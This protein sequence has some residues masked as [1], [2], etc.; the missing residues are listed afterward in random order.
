MG[1][2]DFHKWL[3]NNLTPYIENDAIKGEIDNLYID[4]NFLLHYCSYN[5]PPNKLLDKIAR[6]ITRFI[7]E[8]KPNKRIILAVDGPA[9]Y[10]KM[11]LQ[12]KRRMNMRIEDMKFTP[13]T[14]F[15]NNELKN[16][17]DAIKKYI[18]KT[19]NILAIIKHLDPNE[20]EMKIIG[21]II[22]YPND[23]H[24]IVS[25]DADVIVIV[26]ATMVKNIYVAIL[27]NRTTNIISIDDM[28]ENFVDKYGK[29]RKY[30]SMEFA[31]G[32]LM[33]G[34]D[35][36]PKIYSLTFDKIWKT[37]EESNCEFFTSVDPIEINIE[38][39]NM[40]ITYLVSNMNKSSKNH[41]KFDNINLNNVGKYI[42]GLMWCITNYKYGT[43]E[44]Y[45]FIYDGEMVHPLE[46]LIYSTIKKHN[47]CYPHGKCKSIDLSMYP[48][49][50]LPE[51]ANNIYNNK[52]Q[53][54]MEKINFLHTEEKCRICKEL[55]DN[56]LQLRKH[57]KNHK[58][59]S[60]NEIKLV[61]Q[62]LSR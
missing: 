57:K 20:A 30:P 29:N 21:E 34:N 27:Q 31:F 26:S 13:G 42:D 17:L 12:K 18:E 58:P 39:F 38:N 49:I 37:Y 19:Y 53:S 2:K 9:P 5:T 1:I 8:Y 16:K 25:N 56:K 40:F 24:L 33:M 3:N 43:C 10:A 45:D 60:L 62:I 44:K 35:Y 59:L 4:I 15:F 55:A 47:F 50:V 6:T 14:L 28:I 36:F 54:K 11:I 61:L 48:I 32:S 23:K 22:K 41:L 46:I 51:I 7:N 52:Y